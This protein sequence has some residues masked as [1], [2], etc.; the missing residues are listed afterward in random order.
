MV[1][2]IIIIIRIQNSGLRMYYFAAVIQ[3]LQEYQI[4]HDPMMQTAFPGETE[5][6]KL[7]ARLPSI[8]TQGA[9]NIPA[10]PPA[11][12]T[13]QPSGMEIPGQMPTAQPH[14]MWPSMQMPYPVG[15]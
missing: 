14:Q 12:G 2:N 15:C 11:Y 9:Q 6:T 4:L 3:P 8:A 10:Q 7:D 1:I 13:Q 5:D